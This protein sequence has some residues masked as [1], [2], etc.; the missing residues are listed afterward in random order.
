MESPTICNALQVLE[1]NDK[2]LPLASVVKVKPL[3]T[4]RPWFN[5]TVPARLGVTEASARPAQ[6]SLSLELILCW[7][8]VLLLF[9][10]E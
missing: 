1:A 8:P 3:A 2:V 9:S 7:V 10:D 4:A 6:A 5:L